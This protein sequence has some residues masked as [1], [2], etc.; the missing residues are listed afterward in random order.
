MSVSF[1]SSASS[2][3]IG[4]IETP[5]SPLTCPVEISWVITVR[6]RLIGI[7]NPYPA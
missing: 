7:A 3:V 4:R 5:I 1:A 6:A 2:G